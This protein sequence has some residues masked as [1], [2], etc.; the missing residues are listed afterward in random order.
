MESQSL[1][2]KRSWRD[3]HLKWICGFAN[4]QGGV[5]E[6]GRNDRGEVVG[7]RDTAR[8]LEDLPERVRS[9]LGIVAKVDLAEEDGKEYLRISVEPHPT[10]IAYKGEYH[11]RSGSTKQVLRGPAL[12]RFLL[13]KL[14][15]PWDSA[16]VPGVEIEDLDSRAIGRFR[17]GAAR[18]ERLSDDSHRATAAELIDKL[19]LTEGRYLK[20]AALLLF[21]EDPERFV[22]GAFVRIG[23][24]RGA[25][26]LFEDEV[27]GDLFLQ[28]ERTADLLFTKYSEAVVSYAGIRRVETRPIPP[29][30][31]RELVLNAIIHKDYSANSPVLI[32][33]YGDRIEFWNPGSLPEGWTVGRLLE[34]HASAPRNPDLAAAFF[35]AGQI[36]AWGR[37]T[38]RVVEECRRAEVP[39]PTWRADETGTGVECR[40]SSHRTGR[41]RDL[42]GGNE[43]SRTEEDPVPQD[44]EGTTRTPTQRTTQTTT[45]TPT[46]TTTQTPTQRTTQ[47][48]TQTTTQTPAQTPVGEVARNGES[49]TAARILDLLRRRP[50]AGRRELAATLG[51]ITEDGVKYHLDRLKERG[52]IRRAGPDFGGRWEVLEP[53]D[54]D[55][56]DRRGEVAV[57]FEEKGTTRTPAETTTRTPTQRTTQTTTQTPTQTT[58]Q[59]PTQTTTQTPA[60]RS[61]AEVAPNG[62]SDTAA[63]ILELLRRHPDAGRRELAAALGDITEDGVKYHLDRLKERGRLR[64][65]GPDF[66]GRWEVLDGDSDR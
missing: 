40:Y 10:P 3:E 47:T 16:P 19:R 60:R 49:D 36:E 28:A 65:A 34:S 20:R 26:L 64:R 45:Q 18:L 38:L 55:G 39:V 12:D 13:R 30:A 43:G 23:Y 2:W 42:P 44:E 54:E 27:H 25:D 32:R 21:H 51:E 22:T 53:N 59:T 58:T 5:L 9:V 1:E 4:A 63:R 48:P 29:A 52:Q 46:Q 8:L 7:L 11:Y 66:G 56:P 6:V 17:E 15:R 62:E 37:G 61:V 24:F 35:R 33:V 31:V 50:D 57:R 41:I 14:G